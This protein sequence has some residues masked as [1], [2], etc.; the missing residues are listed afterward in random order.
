MTPCTSCHR[1]VAID[2]PAC[3]FCGVAITPAAP[4]PIIAVARLT[5]SA[6]FAGASL[7]SGCFIER[8][9]P[10]AAPPQEQ[11]PP[12]VR[13][14]NSR[15][16]PSIGTIRGV[17]S[18]IATGQPVE[19][20]WI[21][22]TPNPYHAEDHARN[23]DVMTDGRGAYTI[24]LPPGNYRLSVRNGDRRQPPPDRLVT[25]R[26]GESLNVDFTI[27]VAPP[28]AVPMPY[29]APPRRRRLA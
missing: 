10:P 7:A 20:I 22:I 23:K 4:R 25:L 6:V 9:P 13:A 26:T 21:Q 16:A 24:D 3:P 12:P 18:S 2:E 15:S 19:Q 1:H 8:A 29:G 17:V 28:A 5:R 11:A 14:D 27:T